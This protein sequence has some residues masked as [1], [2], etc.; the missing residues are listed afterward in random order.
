MSEVI[1]FGAGG[2]I[3]R[4][5]AGEALRRGCGVTAVVRNPD[6]HG[7][8][9]AGGVRLRAGDVTDADAVARLAAGHDTAIHAAY[10]AGSPPGVFFPAAAR[11]LLSGLTQAGVGR[12]LVV[13]LSA[14][15]ETPDG[16]RLLDTPAFP[17]QYR[18]FA[19]DHAAGAAVLHD[20]P[21]SLDWLVVS[22][23]GDFGPDAPRHGGYRLSPADPAS[24]VSP[25]DFALA[26]LDETGSPR[27]HRVRIGVAP[28]RP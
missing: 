19:L 14:L 2:R 21:A 15:L 7:D 11:A 22:P 8:L 1:V 23:A 9:G 17:P 3:G 4:A 20:S 10:D 28:Q 25:E 18:P 26:L 6:R 5:V 13:G 24:R 16:V 27:H 12:L